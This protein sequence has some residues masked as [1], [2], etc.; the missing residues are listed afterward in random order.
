MQR[1]GLRLWSHVCFQPSSQRVYVQRSDWSFKV[2]PGLK[3]LY[4]TNEQSKNKQGCDFC[5]SYPSYRLTTLCGGPDHGLGTTADCFMATCGIYDCQSSSPSVA[6]FSVD[7]SF[8]KEAFNAQTEELITW[9]LHV[10]IPAAACRRHVFIIG[11]QMYKQRL[12]T[13]TKHKRRMYPLTGFRP[14]RMWFSKDICR[15][16]DEEE[17]NYKI[18]NSLIVKQ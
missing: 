7:L 9:H 3:K 17:M 2:F 4:N 1:P 15:W 8:N 13:K 6:V 16:Y 11:G 10:K 12:C 5:I 18:I 14:V